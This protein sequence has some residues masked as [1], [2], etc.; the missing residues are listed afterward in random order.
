MSEK[1]KVRFGLEKKIVLGIV[2]ISLITYATSELFIFYIKDLFFANMS[3]VAFVTMTFALGVFWMGI[4]GW[5]IALYIIKPLKRLTE[6]ANQAAKGDLTKEVAVTK[7]NDEIRDLGLAFNQ[8]LHNLKEMVKNV[9]VNFEQT[10]RGVAELTEASQ[11]AAM[12]AESISNTIQ[13]IADGTEKQSLVTQKTVESL[14]GLNHLAIEVNQHT[15]H[16][17]QLSDQMV[18][19]LRQSSQVVHS[20]VEGMHRLVQQNQ[21]SILAVQKLEKNASQIGEISKVVG[22]I[23]E[24]TNLLALN[25]S[26]EAARAGEHGRGFSV[27]AE[28]VRKLADE[29][30]KAVMAINQL[31]HEMQDQVNHVVERIDQQVEIATV[32]SKKGDETTEALINITESVNQVVKSIEEITSLVKSQVEEM[33]ATMEEAKVMVSISEQTSSGNREVSAATQEQT[34]I[35][36]EIAASAQMLRQQ[37]EELQGYIRQFKI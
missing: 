32:E 3:E 5:L 19:N 37:A 20:L 26:I 8:M 14:Q 6:T 35:M 36:E 27:V 31:I 28:E 12:Q 22:E 13:Q 16:C 9:E 23:A 33:R 18:Q 4:L 30:A 24:Q 29:S 15:E 11:H 2:I 17:K 21:E 10:N 34:A 25:A 7:S 1:R